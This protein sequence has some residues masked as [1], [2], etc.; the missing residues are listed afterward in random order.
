MVSSSHGVSAASSSSGG[1]LLESFPCSSRESLSWETVLHKLLQCESLPRGADLQEQAAPVWVP[2]GVTSPASKPALAWAPLF[3]GPQVRPGAC[4][5]VGFPWATASFGCLHLLQRGVLHGLQV[6][7]L[8][9]LI[10]PPW[11]AGGQPASPSWSQLALALSDTG[12]ASGSF[13][14][15]PP[16]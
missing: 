2:H 4:S 6:E 13:S 3:T 11:A 8:H 7:S 9:P 5:S 14:Q 16:L 10:L 1:G 15:K 12:G